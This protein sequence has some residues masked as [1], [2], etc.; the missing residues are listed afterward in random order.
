[1]CEETRAK[2]QNS[3]T[4]KLLENAEKH[5]CE[6]QGEC[7]VANSRVNRLEEARKNLTATYLDRRRQRN[8]NSSR[9]TWEVKRE[10]TQ[11]AHTV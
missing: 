8:F 9:G 1:M 2:T 5:R 10:G 11:T 4:V 6:V 7:T 3:I